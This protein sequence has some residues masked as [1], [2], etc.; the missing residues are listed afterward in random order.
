MK[1]SIIIMNS[2]E[3]EVPSEDTFFDDFSQNFQ[4]NGATAVR[5]I[6]NSEKGSAS[7]NNRQ[8]AIAGVA[9]LLAFC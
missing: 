9:D 3:S 1:L 7:Y 4:K 5:N 6:V 8:A 2:Y